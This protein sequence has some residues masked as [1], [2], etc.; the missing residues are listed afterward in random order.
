MHFSSFCT[1]KKNNNNNKTYCVSPYDEKDDLLL[2]NKSPKKEIIISYPN[3]M[4]S[5]IYLHIFHL[6]VHTFVSEFVSGF[7]RECINWDVWL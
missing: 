2:K 6:I 4:K 3:K 7:Y 1:Q 5:Y